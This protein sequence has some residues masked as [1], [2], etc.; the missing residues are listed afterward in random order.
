[1]KLRDWQI[2]MEGDRYIAKL[3]SGLNLLEIYSRLAR[4]HP[5]LGIAAGLRPSVGLAGLASGGGYG[6]SSAKYGATVD[7]IVAAEVVVYNRDGKRFELVTATG[8]N[9]HSDLLFAVRGGMGGNYGALVSISYD[10]FPVANVVS[11]VAFEPLVDLPVQA[12]SIKAFQEFMHS[13]AAGPQIYSILR[14]LGS[15]GA[16]YNVQC[17]C[18]ADCVTCH[19]KLD[20]MQ[21]AVGI[22]DPLRIEQDFGKSMWFWAGCT[23]DS[24][25]DLYPADGIGSFSEGELQEAMASCLVADAAILSIPY[26]PKCMFFPRIMSIELLESVL[27]GLT[28]PVCGTFPDCVVMMHFQ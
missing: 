16:E 25:S 21:A 22:I 1:M 23:S 8:Y 3:G 5:P 12:Q 19:A 20:T 17:I 9:E 27:E 10:A 4:H 28:L 26:K 11:M 13:D 24:A 6:T 7:R 14:L 18:D 15:S 2:T